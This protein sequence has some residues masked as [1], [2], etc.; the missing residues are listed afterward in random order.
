[1]RADPAGPMSRVLVFRHSTF[2]NSCRAR[3]QSAE[4]DGDEAVTR[5]RWPQLNSRIAPTVITRSRQS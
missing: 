4:T 3:L 1:M 2:K 5:R